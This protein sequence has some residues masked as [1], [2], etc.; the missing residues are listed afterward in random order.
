MCKLLLFVA[1]L[2]CPTPCVSCFEPPGVN[3]WSGSADRHEQRPTWSYWNKATN[4]WQC[5]SGVMRVHC[6]Q[7]SN[8]AW[9]EWMHCMTYDNKTNSTVVATCPFSNPKPEPHR[10][11]LLP[12]NRSQ[13]NNAMC[14]K[15]NRDGL[16]FQV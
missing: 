10:Y 11:M 16:L 5:L 12:E 9:L 8:H 4:Q 1:L 7:A 15:A 3:S 14:D 6:N 2:A 13:L